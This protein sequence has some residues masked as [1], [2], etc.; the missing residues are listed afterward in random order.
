MIH[1]FVVY[2]PLAHIKLYTFRCHY[3]QGK[4]F[5][6]VINTNDL[7][8]LFPIVYGL[9]KEKILLHLDWMDIYYAIKKK[10]YC[11]L[12]RPSLKIQFIFMKHGKCQIIHLCNVHKDHVS[13]GIG[14]SIC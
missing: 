4:M 10:N 13:I 11:L 9:W 12:L 2:T 1:R 7:N 8:V 3:K 5:G 6:L 14:G